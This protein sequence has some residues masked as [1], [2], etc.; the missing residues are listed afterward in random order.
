MSQSFDALME[1]DAYSTPAEKKHQCLVPAIVE[2]LASHYERCKFYK[3]W[4]DKNEFDPAKTLTNLA[5]IPFLPVNIFKRLYLHSIDDASTLRVLKSSATSSQTP[6]QV[7]LDRITRDRQMRVLT[8]CLTHIIGAKRRPFIVLDA[9]PS[10]DHSQSTELSARVAGL[11]G[12]LMASSRTYYVLKYQNGVPVL[13]SDALTQAIEE[14]AANGEEFCFLGYTFVLY[15][16]VVRV[17][18][19]KG[20]RF[21]LPDS[22]YLLHFGGWKKLEPQKVDKAQL[23]RETSDLFGIPTSNICDIYGFTEQ[24]GVIYPDDA[25]G[26]KRTPVYAEALVRD[27][28]TLELVPDGETGLLEFITPVPYSYPGIVVLTDDMGRIVSREPSS[29]GWCGT[30]FEIVGRAKNAE[31][32]GC[33]DTLPDRVYQVV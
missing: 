12:Y 11:R 31:I 27:P 4:C 30:G 19:S 20:V 16:H 9:K 13:D 7:P 24:L 32:R 14:I 3:I 22:T 18:H 17:L 29:N 5:D 10:D 23:N 2:A 25:E 33:G 21:S 8:S 6:S 15:Q 28:V 26:I 1:L